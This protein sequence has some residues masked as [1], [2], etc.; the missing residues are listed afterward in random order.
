V[1]SA[2]KIESVVLLFNVEINNAS[3][4]AHQC[5]IP[6]YRTDNAS[7]RHRVSKYRDECR[8]LLMVQTQ[9]LIGAD[10][11]VWRSSQCVSHH[12]DIIMYA[13]LGDYSRLSSL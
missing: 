9:M 12:D 2:E 5:T 3:D 10:I 8:A 4:R 11:T 6:T 13:A 7:L 1:I